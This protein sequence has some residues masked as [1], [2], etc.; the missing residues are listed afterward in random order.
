MSKYVNIHSHLDQNEN[1]I[2]IKHVN[3]SEFKE[4]PLAGFYSVGFHPWYIRESTWKE[5]L[6]KLKMEV[7]HPAVLA[8]GESGLDKV[9]ETPFSLQLDVFTAM[10]DLSEAI[11]K[12]L[13][14]HCV[15]AYNEII[16]L[17]K[18]YH[19]KQRWII[20]GFNRNQNIASSLLD[21]KMILSFGTEILK[22]DSA[23]SEVLKN[24][25]ENSFFL[26][27]DTS[28]VKMDLIYNRAAHLRNENV[29]VLKERLYS[30][31]INIFKN[32]RS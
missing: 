25:S 28:D 12:P 3:A 18:K 21:Q 24:I 26:E 31:F 19:S 1:D 7:K 17:N 11:Q 6:E 8:I 23:C 22:E 27:S 16:E 4:E 2:S 15:R 9:C 10:I 32:A 30:N 5:K 14:I 29:E 20:H 13:I